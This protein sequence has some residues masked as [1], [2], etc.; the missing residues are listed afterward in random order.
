MPFSQFHQIQKKQAAVHAFIKQTT[1]WQHGDLPI[2]LCMCP[3]ELSYYAPEL[4]EYYKVPLPQQISQS[5]KK[6][7]A[8]FLAGRV[9]AGEALANTDSSLTDCHVTTAKH[10]APSWPAGFT[11]SISHTSRVALAIVSD[12]KAVSSVGIDIEDNLDDELSAQISCQIHNKE[13]QK[14]LTNLGLTS[15]HATT[16]IYSAKE[17]L[18]KALYQYV[19]DYFGFECARVVDADLNKQILQLELESN[20]RQGYALR[21]SYQCDFTFLGASTMTLVKV[22]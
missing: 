19:N 14:L 6:R 11:G 5:V 10:R 3:Y 22:I 12:L 17:S 4:F 13:E 2:S 7:Q 21:A 1:L 18:F 9:A 8:E 15:S 16:L 20:F